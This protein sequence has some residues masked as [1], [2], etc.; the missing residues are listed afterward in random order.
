MLLLRG[1]G[2]GALVP[3]SCMLHPWLTR[4]VST[5]CTKIP[6]LASSCVCS[7]PA[8]AAAA[9]GSRAQSELP[10]RLLCRRHGA[11]C[12]YTPMFHSRLFSVDPK[13]RQAGL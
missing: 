1:S 3:P 9:A 13:Y 6:T 8:A 10:F 7:E 11:T 4:W 2:S 12:A 5:G